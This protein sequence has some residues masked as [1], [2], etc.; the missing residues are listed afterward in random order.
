MSDIAKD[1]F[2]SI[3]TDTA[4]AETFSAAMNKKL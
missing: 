1:L 2:K 4:S 3:V